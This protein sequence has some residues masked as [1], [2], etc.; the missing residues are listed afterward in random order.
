V[1]GISNNPLG[2]NGLTLSLLKSNAAITKA[3][4]S[5]KALDPSGQPVGN[6][7][8][9][10]GGMLK[11]QMSSINNLQ[12]DANQAR[13]TYAVGGDIQLH[14]VMIATEKADLALQLAMQVRNKLVAAYQEI[15]HMTI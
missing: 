14:T 8:E 15:S 13:E 4:A 11:Q 12:T 6:I 2:E 10:F 9:S 5:S 3:S 1:D 7:L